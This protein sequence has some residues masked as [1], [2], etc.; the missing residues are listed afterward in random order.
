M[1][2][3]IRLLTTNK[4]ARKKREKKK[5]YIFCICFRKLRALL[6]VLKIVQCVLDVIQINIKRLEHNFFSKATFE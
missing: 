6:R 1:Y 3:L 4:Y 2:V 5:L